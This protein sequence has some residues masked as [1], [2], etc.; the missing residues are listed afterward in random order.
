[1]LLLLL[2]QFERFESVKGF[3]IEAKVRKLDSKIREADQINAALKSLT[4]TLAQLAFE[5][6]SRIGRL[7]GPIERK[8]SLQIEESLL[9]QMRDANIADIDIARA[10]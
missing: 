1:I 4:A 5:T 3:G 10:V 2:S 9:R 6:M 8:E 7:R